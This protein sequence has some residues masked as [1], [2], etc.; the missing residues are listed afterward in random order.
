MG[1]IGVLKGPVV[2]NFVLFIALRNLFPAEL[3]FSIITCN[4]IVWLFYI[5]TNPKRKKDTK[6]YSIVVDE[7]ERIRRAPESPD[8]VGNFTSLTAT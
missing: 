1:V 3:L 2:F 8:E 4:A 6:R 5:V 7:K